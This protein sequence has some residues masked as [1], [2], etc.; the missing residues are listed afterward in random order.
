MYIEFNGDEFYSGQDLLDYHKEHS[1]LDK[2]V[3]SVDEIDDE[4]G[5]KGLWDLAREIM[6]YLHYEGDDEGIRQGN[7]YYL[8]QQLTRGE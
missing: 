8:L 2:S 6:D 7:I 5:T 4:T 3:T 1:G